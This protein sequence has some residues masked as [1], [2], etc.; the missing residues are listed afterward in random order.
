VPRF[1]PGC[2]TQQLFHG[3]IVASRSVHPVPVARDIPT[4]RRGTSLNYPKTPAPERGLPRPLDL[5]HDSLEGT[6]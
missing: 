2:R 5:C 1:G 3:A 4:F 6:L